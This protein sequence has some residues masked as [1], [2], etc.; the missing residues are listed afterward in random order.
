[1]GL[2]DSVKHGLKQTKINFLEQEDGMSKHIPF[3]YGKYAVVLKL[4]I[5]WF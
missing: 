4:N 2:L 1:M 5:D 3:F